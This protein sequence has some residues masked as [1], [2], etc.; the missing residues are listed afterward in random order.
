[1]PHHT[2]TI[3]L[4]LLILLTALSACTLT[5]GSDED[6]NATLPASTAQ[7]TP[8]ATPTPVQIVYYLAAPEGSTGPVGPIGCDSYLV[9]AQAG[10]TPAATIEAQITAALTALLNVEEQV[11]GQSGLFNALALS[12]LAVDSVEVDGSG[13][14]TVRLSGDVMLSGVCADAIFAAQLEYTVKQFPGISSATILINNV[15]LADVVSGR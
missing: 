9:P 11:V 13:S 6:D 14:A 12:S 3:T 5:G 10:E 1:M 4:T 8:V 15:P 2:R 7:P